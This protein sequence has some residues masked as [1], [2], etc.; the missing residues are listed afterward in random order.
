MAKIKMNPFH[1]MYRF[2]SPQ[3]SQG[4]PLIMYK[5]LLAFSDDAC[6]KNPFSFGFLALFLG[7]CGIYA[8]EQI[9]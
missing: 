8:M 9:Q 4:T 5:I 6:K 7:G 3:V 1:G 2:L